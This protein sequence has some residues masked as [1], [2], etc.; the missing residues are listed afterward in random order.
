MPSTAETASGT[1]EAD[2][3]DWHEDR[4]RY[5][6]DP[7]G[8]VSITGLHWLSEEFDT[9]ADLPGRWSADAHALYVEGIEGTQRLEPAEGA[10][11]LFVE[12]GDRRIEVIRR[13]GSVALRVHDPKAPYL[14]SYRGIPTYAPDVRWRV[15][16]TFTP[17]DRP[18]TVTT[19]AGRRGPRAPPY[20]GRR[21]RR[22]DRRR[23][24]ATGRLRSGGRRVAR[25]VHRRDQRSDDVP[26][27]PVTAGRRTGHRRDGDARLQQSVESAVLVHRLRDLPG[28]AC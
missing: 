25:A 16:G 8:W 4:E 26:G 5:Y 17:Y 28:R 2:W 7:L 27:V 14:R 3:N 9:V 11:G 6:G 21:H 12:A 19:G 24:I 1:F 13:T 18:A 15:V 20:C 22:R 23:A 10:P